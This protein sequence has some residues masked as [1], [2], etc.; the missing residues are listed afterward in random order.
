[1]NAS[2]IISTY[3]SPE[4]LEKVLLGFLCQSHKEF[5]IIIADD[6]STQET[7][8]LIDNYKI[9][10]ESL[11]HVWHPD[12]GFRKCQILN[13]AIEASTTPYLIFTDGDC[14]PRKDF[15]KNHLKYREEGKFLSGGYFKL[16]LSISKAITPEIIE[17]QLCFDTEWLAENGLEN[18]FKNTKLSNSKTLTSILNA[19]TTTKP[20]WNGHNA[21]GW[22]E[23]ILAVNGF[24]ERMKYGGEDRELGER[25]ENYGISGT[26]IRYKAICVHL[27][28]ERSYIKE[29]D[30]IQNKAI[31][32]A[33][34]KNKTVFTPYGIKK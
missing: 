3:N 24:D 33:T 26:Q 23:D 11:V 6:G 18:T 13:K 17:N 16:P 28:H 1:M 2:V 7:A 14:I 21:S 29:E 19:I 31:R 15:L 4:W 22:K 10:F 30:L 12:E 27:D 8:R 5:E 20:S 25:L 9:Q 34:K 32:K